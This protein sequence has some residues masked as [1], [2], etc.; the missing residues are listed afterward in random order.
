MT[1]RERGEGNGLVKVELVEN[2]VV[3]VHKKSSFEKYVC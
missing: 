3:N 1:L 2:K